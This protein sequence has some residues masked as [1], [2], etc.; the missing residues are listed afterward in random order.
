MNLLTNEVYL[1]LLIHQHEFKK[2][3][4]VNL[5][6]D[7]GKTRQTVSKYYQ[8]LLDEEVIEEDDKG[9]IYV[10]NIFNLSRDELKLIKEK[11]SKCSSNYIAYLICKNRYPEKTDREI[12]N[13]LEISEK[14]L[15]IIKEDIKI[16]EDAI[17]NYV[18]AIVQNK[19]IK[20]V[21]STAHLT[22]RIERHCQNRPFLKNSDFIILEKCNKINRFERES[23]YRKLFKP[24]WNE[25]I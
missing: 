12:C 3:S 11:Y 8:A 7:M 20:Y 18:Y 17:D 22:N 10:N 14:S 16:S 23:F 6:K 19:I 25:I 15:E 21:G 13:I 2:V 4:Y 1:Y 5:A 9:K 24:E